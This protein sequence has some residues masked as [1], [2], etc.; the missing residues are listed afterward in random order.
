M[1]V[2]NIERSF[3]AQAAKPPDGGVA[4]CDTVAT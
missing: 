4:V 3:A 1:A 2:S